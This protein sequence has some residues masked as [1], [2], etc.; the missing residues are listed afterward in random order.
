MKA[1]HEVKLMESIS[2]G[3]NKSIN[4]NQLTNG[5]SNWIK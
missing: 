3:L 5:L 4:E 1:I 2:P